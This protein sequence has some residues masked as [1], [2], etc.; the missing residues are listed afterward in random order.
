MYAFNKISDC[1]LYNI[2]SLFFCY[3]IIL[4]F[5]SINTTEMERIVEIGEMV[6]TKE[7]GGTTLKELWESSKQGKMDKKSVAVIV[8]AGLTGYVIYWIW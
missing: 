8:T 4:L 6:I 5:S 2:F 3:R 1:F 7:I